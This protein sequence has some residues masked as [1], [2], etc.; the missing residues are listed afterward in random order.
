M[1]KKLLGILDVIRRLFAN[2]LLLAA[3]AAAIALWIASRP[4]VPEKG[5]LVVNPKGAL[6]EEIAVPGLSWTPTLSNPQQTRMHDLLRAIHAARDD[7]RIRMLVLDLGELAR[8]PLARLRAFRRAI[9]DFK[10]SG[11]KVVA[12]G[13]TYTQSQYYVAAAADRVYLHPMGMV[14]LTG[15]SVYRHY[16][17]DML[18]RMRVKFH[19]FRAGTYKSAADPLVRNHMSDAERSTTMKLLSQL[20]TLYKADV[21]RMRKIRP[22][23]IQSLLDH[24][25]RFARRTHGDL[26]QLA[27]R[28]HLVDA[29]AVRNEVRRK[30]A[31]ELGT[32]RLRTIAFK[33][34]L[35]ALGAEKP[36]SG[37]RQV[38]LLL[39]SGP[40]LS[41]QQPPGA[42]GSLS[43]ARLVQRAVKDPRI[44]AVVVR[45]DSPGGSAI[46][47]ESILRSLREIK[48]AGKPLVVSMSAVAASGGYWIATAADEIW[49]EPA[50]LTGSIGVFGLFPD[51]SAGLEALGIHTDGVQT[52][53]S[54]DALRPDRP[55]S[56]ALAKVI[57][58]SV[59]RMYA[60]FLQ[61]VASGRHISPSKVERM[62]GGRV[63]SGADALRLGL[64]DHLGGL[65]AAIAAAAH[66]AG[67]GDNY[68]VRR[69]RVRRNWRELLLENL[70]GEAQEVAARLHFVSMP[71]IAAAGCR[72]GLVE[73][74]RLLAR[75]GGIYA[76]CDVPPR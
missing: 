8:N 18:D 11:K 26:A 12:L 15:L 56:P 51:I 50:T 38:G 25:E 62:A 60:S 2:A 52:T 27:L 16:M 33:E 21:A 41:G 34:Y 69:I 70:V 28:L 46:A 47:S 48:K 43:F 49:A 13:D 39:A 36:A 63:W 17:K 4:A 19:L 32:P 29:L 20:W 22:A 57:Q 40:I 1:W 53:R 45:I 5:V 59:D 68:S 55:L 3:L 10:K 64:V 7:A 75:G 14:M 71:E 61:R 30:L 58:M 66:R 35:R 23:L 6:V 76:W 67:L 73:A 44:R 65:D 24:P 42:V 31:Q 72:T 74:G 9:V 54:A 37:R